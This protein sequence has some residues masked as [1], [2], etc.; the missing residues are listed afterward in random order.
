VKE[1]RG[2]LLMSVL[3]NGPTVSFGCHAKQEKLRGG[4]R[5]DINS[6][7]AISSLFPKVEV[8]RMEHL[9]AAKI[10]ANKHKRELG[11]I[12]QAILRKAIL[13]NS[14]LVVPLLVD[15]AKLEGIAVD[16][17]AKVAGFVHFY[18][19]RDS[20]VTLYS[21]VVAEAYR[22]VG[23]GRQLFE[24]LVSVAYAHGKTEIRLKCPAEL[25]ANTF[26]ERLG[27]RVTCVETGKCRPL[28]VWTYTL[29]E[30]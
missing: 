11:F 18:V 10:L 25:S 22:H 20:V 26:Y 29:S 15:T 7:K 8:A 24:E 30:Q 28:N 23:M 21:I 1:K 2:N 17:E 14:L 19:R 4:T 3:H 5:E 13:A 16:T 27:L 9:H 6:H 12:N